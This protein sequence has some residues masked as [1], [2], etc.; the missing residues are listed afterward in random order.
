[1]EFRRFIRCNAGCSQKKD[2]GYDGDQIVMWIQG[3]GEP[4]FVSDWGGL[5]K[6][7]ANEATGDFIKE[8]ELTELCSPLGG[9]AT[10]KLNI[11]IQASLIPVKKF[12]ERSKC[13]LN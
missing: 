8:V 12:S 11:A 5:L 2:F 3:G 6:D 9:G 7:A 13:T 10:G 1:M 4:K